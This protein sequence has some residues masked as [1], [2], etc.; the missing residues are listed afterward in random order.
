MADEKLTALTALDP[1]AAE[2]LLYVESPAGRRKG[3]VANIVTY[4]GLPDF[5]HVREEYAAATEPDPAT[6]SAGVFQIRNLNTVKTNLITGASLASKQ[7]TLPA[8]TY[9]VLGRAGCIDL[10]RHQLRLRN[11]TDSETVANGTSE[12]SNDSDFSLTNSTLWGR[13]TITATKVFELQHF[14]QLANGVLGN[15]TG[16]T[17]GEVEV[18]AELWIEIESTSLTIPSFA[19]LEGGDNILLESGD[20]LAL[21]T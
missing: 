15:S 8:G 1:P 5:I 4:V 16:A 19:L 10:D 21:E 6:S 17:Q 12:L 20:K 2:D 11:I 13:F 7:V 14:T 9:R 18:Y 3:T